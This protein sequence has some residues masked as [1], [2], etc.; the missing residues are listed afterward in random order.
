M[1]ESSDA[2]EVDAQG[3]ISLL[4]TFDGPLAHLT[5]SAS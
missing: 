3:K 4:I 2:G 1:A 5:E